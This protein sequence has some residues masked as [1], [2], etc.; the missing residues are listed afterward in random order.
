[1]AV[2]DV[3]LGDEIGYPYKRPAGDV[4]DLLPNEVIWIA[5]H[6]DDVDILTMIFDNSLQMYQCIIVS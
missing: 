1:M 4:F 2:F 6:C 3:F 5:A